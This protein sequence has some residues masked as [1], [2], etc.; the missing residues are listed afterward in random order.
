[1]RK[2]TTL[3]VA[4]ASLGLAAV[5]LP[6]AA[7]QPSADAA[8]TKRVTIGDEFFKA[9]RITVSKGTTVKWVWT[10]SEDHDVVVTKAPKGARKFHS[11][12]KTK[13]TYSKKLKKGGTYKYLCSVH[14]DVM[15][16]TV[17]VK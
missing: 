14:P 16:G 5:A 10:G 17:V 12:T 15:R 3:T 13:G 2:Q 7:S 8:K 1:M 9:K 6:A 11:P 4:L